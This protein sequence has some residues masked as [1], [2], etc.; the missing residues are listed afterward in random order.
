MNTSIYQINWSGTPLSSAE[1]AQRVYREIKCNS[2]KTRVLQWLWITWGMPD[3]VVAATAHENIDWQVQCEDLRAKI[4]EN[5]QTV[6][7]VFKNWF[8][9]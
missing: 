7:D 4:H 1:D 5:F 6:L 3:H 8:P 9:R 2:I